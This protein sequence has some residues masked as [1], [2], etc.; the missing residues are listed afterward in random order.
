MIYFGQCRPNLVD[1]VDFGLF[2]RNLDLRG[3]NFVEDVEE[4]SCLDGISTTELIYRCLRVIP[5][6]FG[7]IPSVNAW[8]WR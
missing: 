8:K 1:L 7:G 4:T 3:P 2:W 6:V 5:A